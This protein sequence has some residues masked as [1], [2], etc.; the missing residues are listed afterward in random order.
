MQTIFILQRI[1]Q[2]VFPTIKVICL[3]PGQNSLRSGLARGGVD[4]SNVRLMDINGDGEY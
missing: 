1:E 4:I 2:S 3:L